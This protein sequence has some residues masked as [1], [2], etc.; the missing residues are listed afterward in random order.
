MSIYQELILDHYHSPHNSGVLQNYD[1]DVSVANSSCGDK[2]RI[3]LKVR[4]EK[5]TDIAFT[6]EGCA[7]SIA[8]ASMLT[9]EVKGKDLE[10]VTGM[11]KDDVLKL[12]NIQLTPTRLRCAL[13]P[14]EGISKAILS[15]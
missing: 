9:D 10:A 13:L 11:T 1:A 4:Q 7:I 3:T 6:G 12:L 15:L 5:I 8:A 2:L 14:L